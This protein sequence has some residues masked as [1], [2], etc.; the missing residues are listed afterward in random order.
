MFEQLKKKKNLVALFICVDGI[1]LN[2][3]LGFLVSQLGVPLY[4]DTVGTVAIASIGGFLPG[5]IVGF[6]TNIFKSIF[7]PSSIYYGALNVMIAIVTALAAR[8][9][10]FKKPKGIFLMIAVLTLIGGGLGTLV[11]LFMQELTFDSESLSGMLYE[12]GIRS[13][14]WS[15]FLANLLIDLPDKAVT[16]FLRFLCSAFFRRNSIRGFGLRA[17]SRHRFP[18]R[19]N[20]HRIKHRCVFFP[21]APRSVLYWAFPW[22]RLPLL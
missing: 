11:P 1:A 18:K 14:F 13:S 16:V 22:L 9:G 10:L 8:R 2:L 4:L 6:F 3:F 5:V 19:K 21:C 17:G 7:D 12:T 15:H 20:I